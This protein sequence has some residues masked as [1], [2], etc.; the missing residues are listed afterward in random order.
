MADGRRLKWVRICDF[1]SFSG[2]HYIE[3]GGPGRLGCVVGPNGSGKSNVIDALAFGLGLQSRQLRSAQLSDLVHRG[4]SSGKVELGV[5][6]DRVFSREILNRA[7]W[8]RIDGAESTRQAYVAE[9]SKMVSLSELA[10]IAQGQVESLAGKSALELSKVI[11]AHIPGSA[12]LVE[13]YE[14][15]KRDKEAAEEASVDCFKKRRIA[16]ARKKMLKTEKDEAEAA[17]EKMA[18]LA[19]LRRDHAL[20]QI[21]WCRGKLAERNRQ[22]QVEREALESMKDDMDEVRTARAAVSDLEVELREAESS[23]AKKTD[24]LAGDVEPRIAALKDL[25]ARGPTKL[26]VEETTPAVSSSRLD[27]AREELEQAREAERALEDEINNAA[28]TPEWLVES[29]REDFEELKERAFE[30]SEDASEL[31]ELASRRTVEATHSL[32]QV[33]A[34]LQALRREVHDIQREREE[35]SNRPTIVRDLLLEKQKAQEKLDEVR[36]RDAAL[37][38]RERE[39]RDELDRAP[40]PQQQTNQEKASEERVDELR[41]LFPGVR[42][43]VVDVCKPT[44]RKYETAAAAAAG[45]LAD[46]VVCDTKECAIDC[47]RYLRQQRLGSS[48]FLPLDSIQ[49]DR[50]DIRRVRDH[51]PR[52]SKQQRYRLAVDCVSYDDEAVA[53][54]IEYA[55]GSAVVCDSLEDARSLAYEG[56]TDFHIKAVTLK[57]AVI[58]K[59][60]AMTAGGLTKATKASVK[61]WRKQDAQLRRDLEAK[62]RDIVRSRR[63]LAID[64]APEAERALTAVAARYE[65][66]AAERVSTESRTAGLDARLA[67]AAQ[68]ES[69]TAASDLDAARAEVAANSALEA[70]AHDAVRRVRAKVFDDFAA[71]A[72]VDP[73]VVADHLAASSSTSASGG[74]AAGNDGRRRLQSLTRRRRQLE[75]LVAHESRRVTEASKRRAA[76][77]AERDAAALRMDQAKSELEALDEQAK[78]LRDEIDAARKKATET[79]AALDRS[80]S[81]ADAASARRSGIASQRASAKR[82][83]AASERAVESLAADAEDAANKAAVEN[84]ALPL[85]DGAESSPPQ[86]SSQSSSSSRSFGGGAELIDVSELDADDSLLEDDERFEEEQRERRDRAEALE[87]DLAKATPNMKAGDLY[88]VSAKELESAE[89]D[90]SEARERARQCVDDF[91]DAK[92]SRRKAFSECLDVVGRHLST[93]YAELTK[94][95]R[96][97]LGGSASLSPVDTDEPY[98]GGLA[99]HATPPSKKFCDIAQLSGGERTLASLAL[100]FALHAYA[101]LNFVLL[102]EVDANLDAANIL[103]LANFL[104][105]RC[106][107]KDSLQVVAVSH[108]DQLYNSADLLI[109]IA[110]DSTTSRAFTLDLSIR[111]PSDDED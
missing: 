74:V 40:L 110:K 62:L 31:V 61:T 58:A 20:W 27:S 53:P 5:G 47:V 66:A 32:E 21:W 39:T 69:G 17:A 79:R 88:K 81:D 3:L 77:V 67:A 97:V 56:A 89:H 98:L 29:V 1:K 111:F 8:Y 95:D 108:K 12:E 65:M 78:T 19:E 38:E 54:A 42:G 49:P 73:L 50:Q 103:K 26:R 6:E 102:D 15:K 63:A 84:V 13:E 16:A 30:E 94:S 34:R 48:V 72:G 28:E 71:R 4:A 64:E 86:P 99:F 23:A 2:E 18:L 46:A 96:H 91:E 57:G 7:C 85:V 22:L 105:G 87:V 51:V 11:E 10:V 90:L 24:R 37:A 80:H 109:G 33:D 76:A 60:G 92:N 36:G 104:L 70:E 44:Q 106:A 107:Q 82:A 41:R 25:V 43:R 35:L 59:S 14:Y 55:M 83:V 68:A 52:A 75:E 45:V 100:L 9:L 93:I 101:D